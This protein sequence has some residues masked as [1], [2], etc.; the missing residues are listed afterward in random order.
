FIIKQTQI[1]LKSLIKN[2]PKENKEK[3]QNEPRRK[4]RRN[5]KYPFL[6]EPRK[7]YHKM[8]AQNKIE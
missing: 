2:I 1:D 6:N 3:R 5:N 4:K 8:L 7:N